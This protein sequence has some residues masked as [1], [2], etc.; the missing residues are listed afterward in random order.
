MRDQG[1]APTRVEVQSIIVSL[2]EAE[3]LQVSVSEKQAL[4]VE[5]KAE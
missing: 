2:P 1:I 5:E 3:A 4:I